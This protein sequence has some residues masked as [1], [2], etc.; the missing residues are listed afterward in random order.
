[1]RKPFSYVLGLLSGI[2]FLT[3]CG[4][5]MVLDNPRMQAV[6]F[7]F[8]D[9]SEY[10][11]GASSSSVINLEPGEYSVSVTTSGGDAIG[12]TTFKLKESGLLH[13]GAGNYVVWRQL[14]GLQ[15]ER[16]TLLNE[17]WVEFDSIRAFGDLKLYPSDWLYI[18]KNWDYDLDEP[19]PDA[20]SLYISSDWVIESKVFR[21]KEFIETYR[22]LAKRNKE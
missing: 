12:D 3:G 19:L 17:R 13:S 11:V 9:G 20:Q 5:N 8:G 10:E 6:V 15:K 1:M 7:T 14:Y 22:E 21:S 18:E 16:K 4:G 2:L